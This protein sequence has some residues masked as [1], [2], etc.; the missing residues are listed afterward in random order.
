MKILAITAYPSKETK[1]VVR[2]F[3]V[4]GFNLASGDYKWSRYKTGEPNETKKNSC[5]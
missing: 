4:R 1:D 5:Y 3:V 2:C